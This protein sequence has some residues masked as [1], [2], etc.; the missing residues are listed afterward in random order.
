MTKQID[1]DDFVTFERW[2]SHQAND[3]VWFEIVDGAGN[4]W[5]SFKCGLFDVNVPRIKHA[6]ERADRKAKANAKL[7]GVSS[8]DIEANVVAGIDLSLDTF[9]LDWKD[10]PTK[11]GTSPAF[12]RD[13]VHAYFARTAV[14]AATGEKIYPAYWVLDELFAL[15][16]D[17][18]NFQPDDQLELPEK[19]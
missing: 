15:A 7:R 4:V 18:G 9:L 1:N 10:I 3:G 11:S 13:K 2:D 16:R 8:K 12:A 14:D 6:V 19:N 5:G 17:A